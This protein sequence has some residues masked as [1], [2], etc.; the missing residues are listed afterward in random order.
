M[1]RAKN[2]GGSVRSAN[3]L[4]PIGEIDI[5]TV[6]LEVGR[7]KTIQYVIETLLG[8]RSLTNGIPNFMVSA[9]RSRLMR[10]NM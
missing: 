7:T 8:R 6:V 9:S 10:T 3:H 4:R 5:A 1:W 2:E